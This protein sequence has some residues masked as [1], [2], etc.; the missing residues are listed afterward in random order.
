MKK[1]EYP[2][3]VWRKKVIKGT[4]W[5]SFVLVLFLSVVAIVRV[6]NMGAD[7]AEA[8]QVQIVEKE[9]N[10]AASVGAQSFAQ[11]FAQQY[12]SWQNTDEGKKNRVER[13]RPYLANGLD[14]QA[15]LLFEGMIWNSSLQQ[16]QVWNVKETGEDTALITLRVH[17]LLNRVIPPDPKEIE[18]SQKEEKEPPKPKEEKAGPYEK[19]FVV[20]VKTDG[21]AFVVYKVPYFIAADKKPEITSEPSIKDN[22]KLQDP[23]LHEEITSALSTFFK[24]Y[25]NGTQEEL[26]YYLKGADI[27]TMTGIITFKEVKN[28]ILKK[29]DSTEE[30]KVH[31]RVIFEENQSKAQVLYPFELILVKEDNRWFVKEMKNQ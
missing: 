6:G 11:N 17:H 14:E 22:E 20:P 23:K 24:T 19:F 16:S 27:Q 26:S 29:G 2:K 7:Q 8:K 4:F 21:K 28:L 13:L 10:F 12:F 30:Y 9:T 3:T 31:A 1:R 18:A 25:T 15:G 5:T